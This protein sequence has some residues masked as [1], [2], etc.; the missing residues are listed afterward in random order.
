M[1][2]SNVLPTVVRRILLFAVVL[3]FSLLQNTDGLLPTVFGA[4]VFWLIPL[5]VSVGM[6]DGEISGLIFGALGGAFWDVCSTVPDGFC[7]FYLAFVGCV[8]GVLVKFVMRNKLLT[9]YC[10]ASVS[11]VAFVVFY[12][13]FTVYIP[14]G[15]AENRNLLGFYLPSA[16]VT[17]LFSFVCYFVV[18]IICGKFKKADEIV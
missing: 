13:L 18:D 17:V 14:V 12:W 6:F 4:R 5:I 2:K 16:V 7:A 3:L 8:A 11:V 1:F 15:D 9:E 10:I